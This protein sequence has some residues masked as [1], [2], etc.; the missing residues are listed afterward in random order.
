MAGRGAAGGQR[1]LLASDEAMYIVYYLALM[2][3][4]DSYAGQALLQ[5]RPLLQVS[6]RQFARLHYELTTLPARSTLLASGIGLLVALN[7]LVTLL[8]LP[9]TPPDALLAG[10]S[11]QPA[12]QLAFLLGN[13]IL[14]SFV[15]HTIHQLPDGQPDPCHG[16]GAQPLSAWAALCLFPAH[17]AH[18][19]GL[20]ARSVPG[21]EPTACAVPDV[22][23][24]YPVLARQLATGGHWSLSSPSLASIISS[25]AR[26]LASKM[27]WSSGLR[28]HSCAS[29]N[30]KTAMT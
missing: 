29:M 5:F 12:T 7:L 2:H 4:L 13:A 9:F 1:P 22:G 14:A 3:Y 25:S 17:G 24:S 16:Y 8:S 21:A 6:D 30:N 15:Y 20:G 23:E 10:A 28:R 19:L 27:R 18:G 11:R 26:K